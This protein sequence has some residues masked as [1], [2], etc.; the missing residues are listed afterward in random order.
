[1]DPINFEDFPVGGTLSFSRQMINEFKGQVALVGLVTGDRDPVGKWFDKDINNIIY[2]YFGI[3]RYKKSDK[4]PLIPIRLKTFV[5]LLF[6]LPRIRKIENRNVFTQSPQ[7]LFAL[8]FFKWHSLCFCFAG[9]TNSVAISRYK[10]LRNLGIIYE[11]NLFKILKKKANV[12]LAAA[13]QRSIRDAITRTGNILNPDD[14]ITF[15]TR[16][17]PSI[18]YPVGKDLSRKQLNFSDD[19]ILLVTTGRLSWVKGWQLLIDATMVLYSEDD[20]K[21]IKL[22]F[23]GEGEDKSLIENYNRFLFDKGAIKLTGKLRQNDLALYLNAADVFVMGSFYEGWPTSLIEALACGC[24]IVTTSF[25]AASEIVTEGKN[26][27]IINDRD[28]SNFAGLVKKALALKEEISYSLCRS[29]RYSVKNLKNDLEKVW[30][31]TI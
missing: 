29:E 22:V 28:P 21:R 27:Y 15:P 2:N 4:K 8:S 1:M 12:I 16:F 14:I 17:D 7:F 20:F 18:F 23:I 3:G 25:S 30:L 31:S 19:E 5:Q 26:G 10:Y 13:D 9:I 6:Y 11:K 24:R